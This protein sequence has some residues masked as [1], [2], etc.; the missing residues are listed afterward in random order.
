LQ[1]KG[2][3]NIEVLESGRL[4]LLFTRIGCIQECS[5]NAQRK[6]VNLNISSVNHCRITENFPNGLQVT[7][8][9]MQLQAASTLIIVLG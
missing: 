8:Q 4:E 5:C 7:D 9:L 6:H 3:K 2:N 1:S